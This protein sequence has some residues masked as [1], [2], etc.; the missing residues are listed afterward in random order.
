MSVTLTADAE[1]LVRKKVES[2][3]YA[4]VDDVIRAAMRLLDRHDRQ[5]QHLLALLDE[6][7][8]GEGVPFT[9]ELEEEIERSS[10][11]RFLRGEQPS[12]DVCP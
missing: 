8:V 7:D 6:G 4:S 11:E 1:S 9:S 3:Q 12:P 10:E 2:G 5:R